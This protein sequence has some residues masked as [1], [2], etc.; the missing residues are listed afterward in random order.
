[1]KGSEILSI[2]A[3]AEPEGMQKLVKLVGSNELLGC[4]LG[5]VLR[6]I[7]HRLD[8]LH[9]DGHCTNDLKTSAVTPQQ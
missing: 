9:Y 5:Y 4:L 7:G 6:S 1:V 8:S 3:G 2:D